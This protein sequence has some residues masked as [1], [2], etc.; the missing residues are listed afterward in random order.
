[1]FREFTKLNEWVTLVKMLCEGEA[2]PYYYLEAADYVSVI[3]VNEINE[4]AF[5]RQ[6]RPTLNLET[7][8][9]PGGIIEHGQSSLEAGVKELLEE[10]G[11]G[12]V[13]I[14]TKLKP[15]F[16]DTV[17]LTLRNHTIIL[18]TTTEK[19]GG[20]ES[21]IRLNWIRIDDLPD[22][23]KNG[24]ISLESHSGAIAQALL[25]HYI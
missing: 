9:L 19:I 18:Q 14:I 10:T 8:E 11:L 24:D 13:N 17:R 21:N 20:V 16:I 4:V 5:V 22:L 12:V 1:M 25:F 15:R 3:A 7:L 6:Y 2:H 23:L